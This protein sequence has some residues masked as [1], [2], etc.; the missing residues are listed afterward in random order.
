MK[1]NYIN[2][3]D[4]NDNTTDALPSDEHRQ[5]VGTL[6]GDFY[7]RKLV[8][9]NDEYSAKVA[10]HS[11]Y[12]FCCGMREIGSIWI[13]PNVNVEKFREEFINLLQADYNYGTIGALTYTRTKNSS[14][15]NWQS[16]EV[17]RFIEEWPG[18]SAGAWWYNPNSGNM[19]Q[20]WTLPLNQP[21]KDTVEDDMYEEDEE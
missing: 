17:V 8:I 14:N 7:G 5:F 18:A 15:Y 2:W 6:Q 3:D 13:R 1:V 11:M 21:S 4:N 12:L 20:Q 10:M 16:N 9:L 19:V